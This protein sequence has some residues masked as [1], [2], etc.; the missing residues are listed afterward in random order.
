MLVG[1]EIFF[2]NKQ[3]LKTHIY[4]PNTDSYTK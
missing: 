3:K 4:I 2:E 1:M